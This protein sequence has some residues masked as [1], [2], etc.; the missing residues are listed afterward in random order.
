MKFCNHGFSSMQFEKLGKYS[1][2]AERNWEN[3]E[4]MVRQYSVHATNCLC[5]LSAKCTCT[6][7]HDSSTEIKMAESYDQEVG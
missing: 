1:K 4:K 6:D 2:N 7:A 3:R 5:G